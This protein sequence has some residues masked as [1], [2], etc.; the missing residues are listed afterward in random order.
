MYT[1]ANF[2][3]VDRIENGGH[4]GAERGKGKTFEGQGRGK[5]HYGESIQA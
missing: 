2:I 3:N 1:T 4:N 5:E